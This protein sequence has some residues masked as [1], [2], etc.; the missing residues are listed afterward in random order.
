M[1]CN[2]FDFLT[3]TCTQV[4]IGFDFDK[5]FTYTDSVGLPVNITGF[6]FNMLIKDAL[7]GA[8][9]LTLPTVND[10]VTTGFFFPSPTTGIINMQI[11]DTDTALIASGT[12][13]YEMTITDGDSKIDI[14]MQG[15]IQFFER[16]F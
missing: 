8:T 2:N 6:D 5:V 4:D 11:T 15:E 12:Y 13:P 1:D 9:L 7:G 3:G 14:F 16:G 10:N